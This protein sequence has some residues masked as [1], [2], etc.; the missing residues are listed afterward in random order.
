MKFDK[1]CDGSTGLN[2]NRMKERKLTYCSVSS[3][4]PVQGSDNAKLSDRERRKLIFA[5]VDVN[6]PACTTRLSRIAAMSWSPDRWVL[7]LDVLTKEKR[8]SDL[9]KVKSKTCHYG[10]RVVCALLKRR[11]LIWTIVA[12]LEASGENR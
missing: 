8:L 7:G 10:E 12:V 3:N 6:I 9:S 4:L 2:E 11:V 1:V 5:E